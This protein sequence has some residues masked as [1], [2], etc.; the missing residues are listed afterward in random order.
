MATRVR[1]RPA[2]PTDVSRY[3]DVLAR[4]RLRVSNALP[5]VFLFSAPIDPCLELPAND[6]SAVD[7]ASATVVPG[8]HVRIGNP[9]WDAEVHAHVRKTIRTTFAP[10]SPFTIALAYYATSLRRWPRPRGA[11]GTLCI[12]LPL[13]P[14][15]TAARCA[16]WLAGTNLPIEIGASPVLVYDLV[17]DG[18]DVRNVEAIAGVRALASRPSPTQFNFYKVLTN[19]DVDRDEL[20]PRDA[21]ITSVL[22]T[23]TMYDVLLAN[24]EW[25]RSKNYP[26]VTSWCVASDSADVPDAILSAP[27]ACVLQGRIQATAGRSACGLVFWAKSHRAYVAPL[28]AL[29]DVIRSGGTAFG[30]TSVDGLLEMVLPRFQDPREMTQDSFGRSVTSFYTALSDGQH[31]EWIERFLCDVYDAPVRNEELTAMCHLL[32]RDIA[33][34]G[35]SIMGPM[36][37]RLLERWTTSPTNWRLACSY[38]LVANLAGVS[39]DPVHMNMDAPSFHE[40]VVDA[41]TDLAAAAQSAIAQGDLKSDAAAARCVLTHSFQLHAFVTHLEVTHRWF[42]GSA[43]PDI[44]HAIASFRGPTFDLE[45][46][47]SELSELTLLAP[48]L[49]AVY[50]QGFHLP[51]AEWIE[52][53][54]RAYAHRVLHVLG[55]DLSVDVRASILG[56]AAIAGLFDS[57][58]DLMASERLLYVVPSVLLFLQSLPTPAPPDVLAPC[59]SLLLALASDVDRARRPARD[60]DTVRDYYAATLDDAMDAPIDVTLWLDAFAFFVMFDPTNLLRFGTAWVASGLQLEHTLVLDVVVRFYDRFPHEM[61]GFLALATTTLHAL[62]DVADDDRARR[63]RLQELLDAAEISARKRA[64]VE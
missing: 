57:A 42:F 62:P 59:S 35:W 1:L 20:H 18:P 47:V 37:S 58:L 61:E 15:T 56:V 19:P 16:I 9:A 48:T 64:R 55:Y 10:S 7:A 33:T 23:S 29:G 24:L 44:V 45:A 60:D 30:Q 41:Y 25:S 63:Q 2:A 38:R 27:Q 43:P 22:L 49:L 6:L 11:F 40:W 34:F 53:V 8:Q 21:A 5:R 46:I 3:E 52:T 36:L 14:E 4:V 31:L 26:T 32:A 54:L 28:S 17:L 12:E 51:A 39:N 13:F 50:R